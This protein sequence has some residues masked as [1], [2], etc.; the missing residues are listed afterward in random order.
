MYP[1]EEKSKIHPVNFQIICNGTL[2][3]PQASFYAFPPPLASVF[4]IAA[5]LAAV[6][7]W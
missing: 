5:S 1:E 2:P 4:S 6:S 7:S 3:I